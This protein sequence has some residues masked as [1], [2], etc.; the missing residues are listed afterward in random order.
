MTVPVAPPSVIHPASCTDDAPDATR[1]FFFF[2]FDPGW[3]VLALVLAAAS[4]A[5][6]LRLNMN[7]LGEL[8]LPGPAPAEAEA[9]AED[10]ANAV[11]DGNASSSSDS[12]S[13]P[14]LALLKFASVLVAHFPP[15]PPFAYGLPLP[16]APISL[17]PYTPSS[18][19]LCPCPRENKP[20]NPPKNPDPLV[21]VFLSL[22]FFSLPDPAICESDPP[23]P[24]EP[25]NLDREG[26]DCEA[27]ID[28][29]AETEDI[30]SSRL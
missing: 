18:S 25:K 29:E 20:A 26:A 27:L 8:P 19:F 9:E 7:R 4:S 2:N 30:E 22:S 16:L 15:F 14:F 24:N 17:P 13:L 10:E 11:D 21:L 28:T 1:R 23:P 3:A 6:S 5:D 12:L